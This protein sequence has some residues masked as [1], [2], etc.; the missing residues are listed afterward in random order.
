MVSYWSVTDTCHALEQKMEIDEGALDNQRDIVGQ[1]H[2]D[3]C[4]KKFPDMFPPGAV[5]PHRVIHGTSTK[6]KASSSV[7][8]GKRSS[9][10]KRRK[11]NAKREE[12]ASHTNDDDVIDVT[13]SDGEDLSKTNNV[14]IVIEEWK[15][16]HDSHGDVNED[17]G[18]ERKGEVVK[19]DI[20]G[21]YRSM[22]KALEVLQKSNEAFSLLSMNNVH[23]G[24]VDKDCF[25]V[26]K[27]LQ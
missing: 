15:R 24:M 26:M 23:D 20:V 17:G 3:M 10:R 9:V 19:H 14:Y 13:M 12:G 21:V 2:V 18:S 7:N 25:M 5:N 6:K 27:E 11:S 22:D 1:L 16:G 4:V 8:K